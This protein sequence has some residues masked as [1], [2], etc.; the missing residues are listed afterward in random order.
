[1]KTKIIAI[2]NSRGVRIPK[3]LIEQLALSEEVELYATEG[4]L[5]IRSAAQPRDGW[6]KAFVGG[7]QNKT[8]EFVSAPIDPSMGEEWTW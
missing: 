5:R 6:E 8:D 3:V 2:G 1:M 7:N 4:E